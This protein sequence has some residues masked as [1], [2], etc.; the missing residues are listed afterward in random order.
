MS[1]TLVRR[2]RISSIIFLTETFPSRYADFVGSGVT[3]QHLEQNG[4]RNSTISRFEPH[5]KHLIEFVIVSAAY[6][7]HVRTYRACRVE[8]GAG[9]R[10]SV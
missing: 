5:A 7:T 9:G 2:N 8:Y 1:F 3:A 4:A 10:A 6:C